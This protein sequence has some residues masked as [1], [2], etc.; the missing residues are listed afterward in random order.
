[1]SQRKFDP[2]IDD[3]FMDAGAKINARKYKNRINLSRRIT[4]YL[5]T[6]KGQIEITEQD[7][8]KYW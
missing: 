2:I 6:Q 4:S 7:P 8:K 1:M 3:C 5:S